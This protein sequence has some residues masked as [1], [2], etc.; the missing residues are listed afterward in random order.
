MK[1]IAFILFIT[2]SFRLIS[3]EIKTD[4][5]YIK[6]EYM[7]K[8]DAMYRLTLS[9]GKSFYNDKPISIK[10]YNKLSRFEE[11]ICDSLLT[12]A[13]GH[14]CKFYIKNKVVIEEG[15]WFHE[16]MTGIH[17]EYFNNGNL[18]SIGY[19]SDVKD[20]SDEGTKIGWWRY[21]DKHGKVTSEIDYSKIKLITYLEKNLSPNQTQ[22]RYTDS[23]L[24]TNQYRIIHMVGSF[25]LPN[26]TFFGFNASHLDSLAEFLLSHNTI[27]LKIE[28]HT[29]IFMNKNLRRAKAFSKGISDYLIYKGVL[30][31]RLEM[32]PVGDKNPVYT[33]DDF[34][35][36]MDKKEAHWLE[37]KLNERL[38][39]VIIKS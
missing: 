38:K 16:F 15:R 4:T 29:S 31:N 25:D 22:F 1:Q 12:K 23:L 33:K 30:K 9:G 2:F 36:E 34:K 8:C 10:K 11:A 37:N 3:Q 20:G 19:Y 27:K 21:Y 32:I 26:E 7:D 24:M 6:Q 17:K 28:V 13:D 5:F 39:I 18:K 35:K 14:Y